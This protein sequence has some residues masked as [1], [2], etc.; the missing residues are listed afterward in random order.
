[1]KTLLRSRF[2]DAVRSR[3]QLNGGG[4]GG[5]G[6][7]TDSHQFVS[8][9]APSTAEVGEQ[10]TVALTIECP[11]GAGGC[12][13]ETV[14]ISSGQTE[15]LREENVQVPPGSTARFTENVS[16]S[17]PGTHTIQFRRGQAARR[18]DVE[19][20]E[21]ATEPEPE[22]TFSASD[23]FVP[24]GDCGVSPTNIEPGDTVSL[25]A[26]VRNENSQPAA[27]TVEWT[28]EG[29]T[30]AQAGANVPAG[31]E[32]TAERTVTVSRSGSD[33]VRAE[34]TGAVES[35][36]GLAVASPRDALLAAAPSR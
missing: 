29:Q 23:V 22:P 1:M 35:V 11:S 16:F 27:A 15:F 28:W 25:G 31:S 30:I 21:S 19:V 26:T 17:Q 7:P 6:E 34:V 33:P 18:R 4:G 32:R 2:P 3:Q 13:P 14:T 10:F 12:E 9:D 5:G 36:S 24:S 8:V 20:V